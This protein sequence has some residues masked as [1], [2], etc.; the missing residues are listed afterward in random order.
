MSEAT[1]PDEQGQ[2]TASAF[3]TAAGVKTGSMDSIEYS[4]SQYSEHRSNGRPS[5]TN[6][7][8]SISFR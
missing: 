7:G 1:L 8:S 2:N 5:R 3:S 6:S 4:N